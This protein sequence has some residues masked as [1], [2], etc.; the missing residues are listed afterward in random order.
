MEKEQ[1]NLY[2]ILIQC[3]KKDKRIPDQNIIA[4]LSPEDWQ[5]FLSLAAMQRIM[6]LLWHRL[7]QKNLA[8]LVPETAAAQFQEASRR[9]TLN[10]LRLNTE[11][12]RL[13]AAL[14]KENI[15]LI[16]LKG[17]VLSNT[18]YENISLREM[19]D[20]DV[21]AR[22]T[23]LQRIAD[24]L[25]HMGYRSIQ[26]FDVDNVIRTGHHLPRFIKKNS[27]HFEIHCNITNPGAPHSIEP[28]GLWLRA[29]PVQIAGRNTL[30]LS[31]E[32]MLLH[33]CLHTSYLHPF[34]FGLRPFCDIAETIDHFGAALDW[35]AVADRAI[36]QKW[37]RGVYLALRLA[38]DLAGASAPDLMMEKLKPADMSDAILETARIQIF[39]DKYFAASIPA[40]FA[41]LLESRRLTDKIKI[42]FSRVFLPRDM[43]AS[44][45]N[46][47]P[48]NSLKIYVCYL[49]RFVDVLRR[50]GHT[51]QKYQKSNIAVQS[52]AQRTKRIADW[53]E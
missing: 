11:L 51:L 49:R 27:A 32:D 3:L 7:K 19:N 36:S 38:I 35:Q 33:L 13:L 2:G 18:V 50:H 20:I 31:A 16:P 14:E 37:Q 29:M 25:T 1:S 23:D 45:Y 22:P 6:P 4:A 21:L 8:T 12:S 34:T 17:I 30:M 40:P 52:L 9:N 41:E 5:S 10:N 48:I 42:F 39:T 53:I 46:G 15:P 26:P 28:Q 47:V 43:I 44:A 24:I